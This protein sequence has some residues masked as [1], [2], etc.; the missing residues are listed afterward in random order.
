MEDKELESLLSDLESDRSER[1]ESISYKNKIC[2]TICAFA[3]DLPNNRQPGVLFIGARDDGG[4]AGLKINDRLL[5]ALSDIRSEGNILPFPDM[6]VEKRTINNCELVIIIVHPS[7]MPPVRYRGRVYVRV[8]PT[9]R[10]ATNG[11]ERRLSEKRRAGDLPYDMRPVSVATIDDLDIELFRRE[12]LPSAVTS[13]ILERN[14]RSIGDQLASLRFLTLDGVPTIAGILV[15]GKDPRS[16]ISGAY[17]QFLRLEGLDLADSIKDQKEI[18][19]PLPDLLR[20]LDE[21]LKAHISVASDIKSQ[22]REMRYPDYPLVALQQL[23]RNAVLH[24][25]YEVGNAPAR[26]TW[27]SDRIEISSPGGPF[28]LVTRENFGQPNVTSYRNPQL[29]EAMKTL[30][31]VQRFGVGIQLARQE[32][33]KNGNPPP[34][35]Q[36]GDNYILVTVRPRP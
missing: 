15:F 30:G 21:I 8:G 28:G 3:N 17:V 4:C 6:V 23:A 29:A 1:K 27:F 13:D 12:Y 10:L 24:R 36:C 34:E 20:M 14:E 11:E 2:E 26:L 25:T 35:F 31:Y 5:N 18:D 22:T 16:F 7:Y 32:L 33:Q 9:T 19:G